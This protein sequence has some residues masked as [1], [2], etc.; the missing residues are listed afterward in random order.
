M[1]CDHKPMM[2]RK[3][4]DFVSTWFS[5]NFSST[6]AFRVFER[7]LER[8]HSAPHSSLEVARGAVADAACRA[9]LLVARRWCAKLAN[10]T[11]ISDVALLKRLRNSE[12]WLRRLCVDIASGKRRVPA[13]RRYRSDDPDY[14]WHDRQSRARQGTNG[15]FCT[16]SDCRV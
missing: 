13:R 9:G 8:A 6:M 11:D 5:F 14:R 10:W 3:R 16:A 15:G 1:Q 4:L 7:L 12:E 2:R